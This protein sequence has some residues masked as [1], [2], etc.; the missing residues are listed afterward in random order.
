M[1]FLC[2]AA[3]S[4]IHMGS[5]GSG[6]TTGTVGGNDAITS[7]I[8]IASGTTSNTDYETHAFVIELKNNFWSQIGRI[9]VYSE[10]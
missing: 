7:G 8:G 5:V 9:L 3:V 6:G 4:V 1:N 10:K 2:W